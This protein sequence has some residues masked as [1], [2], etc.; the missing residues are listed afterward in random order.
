MFSFRSY[1]GDGTFRLVHTS[2]T[3]TTAGDSSDKVESISW[4]VLTLGVISKKYGKN[5]TRRGAAHRSSF[6]ELA[7]AIVNKESSDTYAALFMGTVN[8]IQHLSP[9]QCSSHVMMPAIHSPELKRL[10]PLC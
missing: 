9:P 5:D 2:Q 10:V 7:F 6:H 1:T 4:I 8:A 3:K